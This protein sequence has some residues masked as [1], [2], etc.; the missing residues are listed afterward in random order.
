MFVQAVAQ[1]YSGDELLPLMGSRALHVHYHSVYIPYIEKLNAILNHYP[2]VQDWP[3]E[4]LVAGQKML[5]NHMKRT[6][7]NCGGGYLNHTQFYELLKPGGPHP[8]PPALEVVFNRRFGSMMRFKE[9]FSA[10]AA[11]RFGAGWCWLSLRDED[12]YISGTANQ[13]NP[14]MPHMTTVG[15]PILGIDLW[16]HTYLYDWDIRR[17][18]Y[19]QAFWS[20][21]NW[22]VVHQRYEKAMALRE[23]DRLIPL[24]SKEEAKWLRTIKP[25]E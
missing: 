11:G 5:P 9:E 16:E 6:I 14:I 23:A 17:P 2:D 21:I 22:E 3:V 15:F 8:I 12:L 24:P 18:A 4:K 1:P 7:R 19:V 10:A 25:V 13:D 20:F